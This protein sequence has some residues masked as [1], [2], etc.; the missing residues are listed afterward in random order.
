MPTKGTP[1]RG[2]LATS[3]SVS[4][5]TF[6]SIFRPRGEISFGPMLSTIFE[7]SRNRPSASIIP[8]FS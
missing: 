1:I 3:G 4:G 7:R 6:E 2:W 8:G 5:F